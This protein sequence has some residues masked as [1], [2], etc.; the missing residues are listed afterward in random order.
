MQHSSSNRPPI[1]F[2]GFGLCVAAILAGYLGL[3]GALGVG[4]KQ[5]FNHSDHAVAAVSSSATSTIAPAAA[6][7]VIKANA[8]D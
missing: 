1:T 8:S 4:I 6:T 3:I 2:R 5:S 7:S